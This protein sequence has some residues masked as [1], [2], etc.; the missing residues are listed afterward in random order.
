[1]SKMK[2]APV[3][4]FAL[5]ATGC[6]DCGPPH[7][8]NTDDDCCFKPNPAYF[9]NSGSC[10]YNPYVANDYNVYNFRVQQCYN[11]TDPEENDGGQCKA[12][13]PINPNGV[14][15]PVPEMPQQC[16]SWCW[17]ASIA[18]VAG[19]YGKP[20]SECELAGYKSGYGP[21]CCS[22]GACASQC[23]Q[24]ATPQEISY[25][26]GQLGIHGSLLGSALSEH[27]LQIELS[28]GRPV[29]TM[30]QGSFSGHAVVITGFTGG[31][32]AIYHV[33]DPWYGPQD[34][35]YKSVAWGPNGQNW[36]YTIYRLALYAD[37]CNPSFNSDCAACH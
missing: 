14:Y 23:N 34:I 27:Q 25:M 6:D 16:Q 19:Y 12:D 33:V 36:H 17:A 4:L 10:T 1:M 9:C 28:S 20:V 26:L 31:T 7:D 5:V 30:F 11:K 24:T 3:V 37:G 18:M 35:P 21:S 2:L 15:L 8:C 13:L 22:W 29:Y 32:P